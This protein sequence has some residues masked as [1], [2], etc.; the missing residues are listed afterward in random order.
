MV[1]ETVYEKQDYF[2]EGYGPYGSVKVGIKIPCEQ[3]RVI[4]LALTDGNCGKVEFQ[5]I[6]EYAK[7]ICKH[8]NTLEGRG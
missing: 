8:M 3:P 2:A 4:W 7:E 6:E 5:Q 1:W